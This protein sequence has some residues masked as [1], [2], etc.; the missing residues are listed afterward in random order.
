MFFEEEQGMK[1]ERYWIVPLI[2]NISEINEDNYIINGVQLLLEMEKEEKYMMPD[3]HTVNLRK[4]SVIDW[5][6]RNKFTKSRYK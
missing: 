6:Y 2:E 4:A 5:P 1:I 3:Y